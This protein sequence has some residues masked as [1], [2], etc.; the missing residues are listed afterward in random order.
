MHVDYKVFPE[1]NGQPLIRVEI[2][3]SWEEPK[4]SQAVL[5]SL[6]SFNGVIGWDCIPGSS[7]LG[8]SDVCFDG[9][10]LK[11]ARV[12]FPTDDAN[13]ALHWLPVTVL[14][15]QAYPAL[16]SIIHTILAP[17]FAPGLVGID[18]NDIKDILSCGKCGL[19]ALVSG[20]PVDAITEAHTLVS[21]QLNLLGSESVKGALAVL[22]VPEEQ[23]CLAQLGQVSK[24][25][26]AMCP[27]EQPALV[28][29]PAITDGKSIFALLVVTDSSSSEA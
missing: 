27:S 9:D 25:L 17:A 4:V 26:G 2:V 24:L 3:S 5:A 6:D 8:K 14:T 13:H 21:S 29:A 20:K 1:S 23:P 11:L 22:F 28:S 18:W 12:G 7:S 16:P 15:T 19:L 10:N